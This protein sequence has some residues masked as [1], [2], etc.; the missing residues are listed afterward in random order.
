VLSSSPVKV[1]KKNTFL[2]SIGVAG[3]AF[4]LAAAARLPAHHGDPAVPAE[5]GRMPAADPF[6]GEACDKHGLGRVADVVDSRHLTGADGQL[7]VAV[8]QDPD[9]VAGVGHRWPRGRAELHVPD[10]PAPLWGVQGA[11]DDLELA[12]AFAALV[13]EIGVGV[14]GREGVAVGHIQQH[15]AV[16]G[17]SHDSVGVGA[18]VGP[19]GRD[20]VIGAA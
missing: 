12:V 5:R 14:I 3:F 6:G 19:D 7:P 4:G 20:E 8:H 10:D 13:P 15:P 1:S 9:V 2:L 18:A 11:L 17:V 16:F